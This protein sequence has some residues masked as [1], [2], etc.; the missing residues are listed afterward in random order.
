MTPARRDQ[1]I[2]GPLAL[3][4][5]RVCGSTTRWSTGIALPQ[6]EVRLALIPPKILKPSRRGTI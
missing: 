5:C 1:A 2:N 3:A 4:A 6:T